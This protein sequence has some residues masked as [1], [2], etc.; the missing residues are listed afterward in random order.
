LGKTK[1]NAK[2]GTA[3]LTIDVPNPGELRAS[4]NGVKSSG[5]RAMI[6]K[7][8][9][10]PGPAKLLIKAKGTKRKTLNETGKVT[11]RLKITY[12][13]TGGDPSTQLTKVTLRR[14]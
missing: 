2:K 1:R 13:P 9:T 3:V 4:G 8:V 11:L 10:A 5:A 6:S 12:T 7:T 14:D